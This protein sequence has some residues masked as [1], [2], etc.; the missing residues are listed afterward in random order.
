[1]VEAL[2]FVQNMVEALRVQPVDVCEVAVIRHASLRVVQVHP[3]GAAEHPPGGSLTSAQQDEGGD[4]VRCILF[5]PE[6]GHLEQV[7]ESVTRF[8]EEDEDDAAFPRLFHGDTVYRGAAGTLP[9]VVH[10]L[11]AERNR[12][13]AGSYQAFE[14]PSQPANLSTSGFGNRIELSASENRSSSRSLRSRS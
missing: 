9:Q 14:V 13:S 12:P 10:V 7:E 5:A 1:M 3:C 4:V 6:D 11:V 2:S 8:V